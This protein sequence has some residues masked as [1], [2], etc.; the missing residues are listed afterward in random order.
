MNN[1]LVSIV[2][3][4]YNRPN[5][6]NTIKSVLEQS[7]TNFELLIIDNAS[8]DNTVDEINKIKDKRIKLFINEVNR[9]QTYSINRGLSLS[10]GK[11]IARID[12]DDLMRKDRLERQVEYLEKHPECVVCGSSVQIIDDYDNKV[13]IREYCTRNENIKFFSTFGCP[14]AH[15]AVMLRR[16]TLVNNE[17]TYNQKFKMAEDYDMWV[18]I[19]QYG[20]GANISEPLTSY[21]E[22]MG[23]D[24]KTYFDL[25]KQETFQIIESVYSTQNWSVYPKERCKKLFDY[26]RIEN[27]SCLEIIRFYIMLINYFNRNIKKDNVDYFV[28]K[29]H[30]NTFLNYTCFVHN[31]KLFARFIVLS[32]KLIKKVI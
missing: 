16:E 13:S 29:K 1:P 2:L 14:F 9:G 25:M 11:Y 31:K 3:P 15:P 32:R 5:V 8:T 24:S 18:R 6:V 21:R 26:A 28:I 12:S 7:F 22:G 23:N 4:V 27:K 10:Q 17:L 19:L 30:I 20:E